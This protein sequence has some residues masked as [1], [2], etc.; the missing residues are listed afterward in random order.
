[1]ALQLALHPEFNR[2]RGLAPSL[3]RGISN[4]LPL[5]IQRRMIVLLSG[6]RRFSKMP[7]GWFVPVKGSPAKERR[8]NVDKVVK[9]EKY[10][11]KLR[12]FWQQ[13]D[14]TGYNALI[15]GVGDD[16]IDDFLQEKDLKYE[17]EG[18]HAVEIID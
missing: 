7:R 15:E 18:A 1:V 4:A 5:S 16:K 10:K 9:D 14:H 13:D 3:E 12:S 11:G 2:F 17:G 8:N 6:N